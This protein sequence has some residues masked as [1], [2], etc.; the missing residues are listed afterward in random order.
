[1]EFQKRSMASSDAYFVNA[2]QPSWTDWRVDTAVREGYKINPWVYRAI[3]LIS[4]NGSSVPWVLYNAEMNPQWNHPISK[5]LARPNPYF[6]RQRT[7]ELLISWLE[8]S[9]NAYLKKVK[10]NNRTVEIWPISPDRIAPIPSRD[11]ARFIDGYQVI[12]DGGREWANP[13]YNQETVIH[14]KL[15][16]PSNPYE[17]ISPLMAA[18]KSVDLDNSQLDWNTSTMQNRGVVDGVFT[19]KRPIDGNQ[20][21][22]IMRRIMDKFGGKKNARKPLVI[23]DDASYTRLS[24]NAIELDF[25]NSRKHNR[26]EILSVFGVPPQLIGIQDSSTYNNYAI[27]MRIFWETTVMPLLDM[28]RDTL[29]H[30]MYD[31]IPEGYSIGYDISEIA[32]L[33]NNEEEKANIAK[34]YYEIGVPVSITNEKLALGLPEYE[35]WDKVY[36]IPSPGGDHSERD[37]LPVGRTE[38]NEQAT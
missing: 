24:L 9:G 37:P 12:E 11:P 35:G 2:K 18:A 22:G 10:V 16:D 23:G 15:T 28:V 38:P 14:L 20:A 27:S 36:H 29:N 21:E 31:E 7:M 17:G 33:R 13:D 19:F 25:L 4:Q 1:M 30:A 3:Q 8:L 5:M 32:A 26:E 34:T 6:S